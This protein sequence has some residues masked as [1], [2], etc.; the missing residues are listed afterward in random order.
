MVENSIILKLD[1]TTLR[2]TQSAMTTY[3]LVLEVT[4]L[5][6]PKLPESFKADY[7]MFWDPNEIVGKD[8]DSLV[9]VQLFSFV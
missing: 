3:N 8:K 2:A 1:F 4:K 5:S 9:K 6:Y 7:L